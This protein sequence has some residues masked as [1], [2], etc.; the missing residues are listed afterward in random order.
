V[1]AT[2][3]LSFR[4][5]FSG[6]WL[7]FMGGVVWILL[8]TRESS[9]R[10]TARSD[11]RW[12]FVARGLL[13]PFWWAGVILYIV[14]PDWLAFLSIPLSDWFRLIT[15]VIT[16]LSIPLTLVAFRSLGK[17]WVHVLDS[18][19]FQQRR[20]ATLVTSGHYHY[21][22]HPMY[23]GGFVFLLSQSLVAATWLLFLTALA[24]VMLFYSQI[25]KEERM[26]IEK[27]GDEYRGYMKGTPRF[28][29]RARGLP[30]RKTQFGLSGD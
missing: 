8:S 2:D 30:R 13:P 12:Y 3:E 14:F 10:Q 20:T 29:P 23:L 6:L 4:I 17:N 19:T 27:F 26:L 11:R 7:I 15:A 22:R 21:S 24:T 25:G 9:G 16:S 28:I 5:V 18:S 1:S